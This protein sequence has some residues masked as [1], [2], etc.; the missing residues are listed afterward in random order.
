MVQ[1]D[2]GQ[3]PVEQPS[4]ARRR[5][6][7]AGRGR[8][9]GQPE[10]AEPHPPPT[11]ND[12]IP[13]SLPHAEAHD[14]DYGMTDADFLS[15]GL[16][17]PSFPTTDTQVGPIHSSA[18]MMQLH[19]E[20][21]WPSFS[22]QTVPPQTSYHPVSDPSS[23]GTPVQH[24]EPFAH[25]SDSVSPSAYEAHRMEG[26]ESDES[27]G[28]QDIRG[29]MEDVVDLPRRETRPPPC[30]TGGCRNARV[31]RRGRGRGGQ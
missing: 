22:E 12:A 4:A 2:D 31:V 10:L 15:L 25:M 14:F 27:R 9:G 5:R 18:P 26:I 20:A 29:H 13:E 8:R 3:L 7:P 28:S 6:A 21:P 17:G 1:S 11:E 24:K 30:G 16:A 19:I 23:W